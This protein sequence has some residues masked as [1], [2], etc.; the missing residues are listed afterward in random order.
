[1]A[2]LPLLY[3]ASPSQHTKTPS[4]WLDAR[5]LIRCRR[6]RG[7]GVLRRAQA[8]VRRTSLI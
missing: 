2:A 7:E 6:A 1:L 3:R 5:F 4:M 8:V